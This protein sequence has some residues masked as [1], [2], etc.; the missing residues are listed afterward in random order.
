MRVS[1]VGFF[2]P[3]QFSEM[4]FHVPIAPQ[5]Q[6]D[7]RGGSVEAQREQLGRGKPDL[8]SDERVSDIRDQ[9][10]HEDRGPGVEQPSEATPERTSSGSHYPGD[11]RDLVQSGESGGKSRCFRLHYSPY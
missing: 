8:R 6:G 11:T 5:G 2:C 4:I 7:T 3:D 1:A 9:G 10:K